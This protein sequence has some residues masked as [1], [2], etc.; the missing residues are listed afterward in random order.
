MKKTI[1]I[2]MLL[3]IFVLDIFLVK[4]DLFGKV[5]IELN[6]NENTTIN[7]FDVYVDDGSSILY[8]NKYIKAGLYDLRVENGIDNNILGDY[9]VTYKYTYR[10][11][12]YTKV[13][14]VKVVDTE[15]PTIKVANEVVYKYNGNYSKVYYS[16]KDNYDGDL[17]KSVNV[18]YLESEVVLTV[19]DSSGN[20]EKVSIPVQE[21]DVEPL[22]LKLNGSPDYYIE[23]N[24]SYTEKGVTVYDGSK[25]LKDYEY[26]ISSDVDL[27]K[28]GNYEITYTVDYYGIKTSIFRNIYV[29]TK[30]EVPTRE[31]TKGLEKVVYLTFDDGPCAYTEEF[32]NI[33]DQYDAKATFFVT[34]QFNGKYL[35]LIKK[36][37]DKGHKIAVHTD[38][39]KYSIYASPETYINDFNTMNSKIESIIGEKTN[40][41]RFPG[42]SSNTIS[43]SYANGIMKYLANY[44]ESE[45]YIYYDW[46]VDSTDGAGSGTEKIINN[47]LNGVRKNNESVVL[48]H[49]IH[50]STL[51]ALPTILETLKNE[52]YEFR[53]LDEHSMTAHH[54]INN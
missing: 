36:E 13:R 1:R 2:I 29:Y 11:R 14:N 37:Y 10:K 46:N 23:V 44:M 42:G 52:G 26:S 3:V 41:F 54:G 45:G 51:N 17:T 6:G 16:A 32:L 33:L 15:K 19:K 30:K 7:V 28:E 47:V 40:L 24:G 39:H 27:T 18:E 31:K 9:K 22:T 50:K 12:E 5:T 48:M 35:D 20:E 43:R 38:T 34:D 8:D 25:E 49:D 53:T 4:K 21:I